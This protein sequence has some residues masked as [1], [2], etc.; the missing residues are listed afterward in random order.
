MLFGS[1]SCL[2]GAEPLQRG[3]ERLL[4][5]LPDCVHCRIE[6]VLQVEEFGCLFSF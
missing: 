4:V 5:L 6:E 3:P 1:S 2:A